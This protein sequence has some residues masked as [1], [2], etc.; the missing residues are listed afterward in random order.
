[1]GR[2]ANW[3]EF[4]QTQIKKKKKIWFMSHFL[5]STHNCKLQEELNEE[6]NSGQMI[7]KQFRPPT[8]IW[9]V[10]DAKP[11]SYLVKPIPNGY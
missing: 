2:V 9:L 4:L 10:S 3:H 11:Q 1:M 8:P 6:S 7:K 5:L